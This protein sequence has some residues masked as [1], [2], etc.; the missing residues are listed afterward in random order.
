MRLRPPRHTRSLPG[1]RDRHHASKNLIH[2]KM[3]KR[4]LVILA[5]Y[6]LP[7]IALLCTY[8][9]TFST[10]L[11]L[12]RT[13]GADLYGLS[14][15]RNI[16]VAM[17][18]RGVAAPSPLHLETTQRGRFKKFPKKPD[19]FTPESLVCLP[20]R[21]AYELRR[22][23]VQ[24]IGIAEMST[25]TAEPLHLWHHDDGT[26]Y[27]TDLVMTYPWITHPYDSAVVPQWLAIALA[28]A[29]FPAILF[30]RHG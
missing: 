25:G 7:I 5:V 17:R 10:D 15:S 16:W 28:A 20:Q 26:G 18:I 8:V 29:P 30:V 24:A 6:L 2:Q 4:R 12:T 11:T 22:S 21:Q 9:L 3:S 1:M 23:Q 27:V 13:V 14:A 19:I